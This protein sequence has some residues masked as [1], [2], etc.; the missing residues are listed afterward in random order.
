MTNDLLSNLIEALKETPDANFQRWLGNLVDLWSMRKLDWEEDGS[1]LMTEAEVYYQEAIN[2]H[3]WGRKAQRHD[4]V[5]A[6][7]AEESG[8]EEEKEK[9]TEAQ[10]MLAMATRL[11]KYA[12]AYTAKWASPSTNEDRNKLY[13]WKLIPPKDNEPSVK[14]MLV[15]G[16]TK[17][18]WCPNHLQWMIH[19]HQVNARG[20]HLE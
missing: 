4:T 6:F 12:E 8:S 14:K 5:Y 11:K 17:T 13:A 18:Y 2:T 3:K 19:K 20:N 16:K 7:K 15:E 9:P 10:E 1:D